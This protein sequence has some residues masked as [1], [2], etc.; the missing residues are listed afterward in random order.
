MDTCFIDSSSAGEISVPRAFHSARGLHSSS[1]KRN[2]AVT[3]LHALGLRA[4]MSEHLGLLAVLVAVDSLRAKATQTV[5]RSAYRELACHVDSTNTHSWLELSLCL[6]STISRAF[7]IPLEQFLDQQNFLGAVRARDIGSYV[8]F[9]LRLPS[10][11]LYKMYL[12][13]GL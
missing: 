4:G 1:S 6:G 13:R 11:K 9:G 5:M 7:T 10:Y 8:R 2:S 3:I 12:H